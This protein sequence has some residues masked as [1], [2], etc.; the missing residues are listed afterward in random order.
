[1]ESIER[2]R[3][4]AE[5]PPHVFREELLGFVDEIERE[6]AEKYVMRPI[7]LDGLLIYEGDVLETV[8]G[9]RT[10]V[11]DVMATVWSYG[12]R[13]SPSNHRHVK[14]DP[15]KELLEELIE[16]AYT[17]EKVDSAPHPV[18]DECDIDEIAARIREAVSANES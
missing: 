11:T 1:M 14:P 6:I 15:V 7:G 16:R 3:T 10:E 17:I 2:L 8:Y 5:T 13:I 18:V 4:F 12:V 9:E